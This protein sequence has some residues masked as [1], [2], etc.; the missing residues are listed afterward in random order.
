MTMR[1]KIE[2]SFVNVTTI[3][4]YL[5]LIYAVSGKLVVSQETKLLVNNSVVD[6]LHY[7]TG[8]DA[9]FHQN[10]AR[11]PSSTTL[12]SRHNVI[13]THGKHLQ[14]FGLCI[15]ENYIYIYTS[16]I[17]ELFHV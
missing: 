7:N 4:L 11:I 14:F 1:V 6:E 13:T 2:F 16:L 12:K 17:R 8:S 10:Y 9:I 3:N 15:P 5:F